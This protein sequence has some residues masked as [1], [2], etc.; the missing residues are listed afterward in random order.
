MISDQDMIVSN[1]STSSPPSTSCLHIG[2][3][4]EA[5]REL[6]IL[7]EKRDLLVAGPLALIA[8]HERC[9]TVGKV[10]LDYSYNLLVSLTNI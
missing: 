7:Q 2:K 4:T 10:Q 3:P 8:A 6:Q 5:I 1:L 9:S